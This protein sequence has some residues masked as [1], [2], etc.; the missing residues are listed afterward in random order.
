MSVGALLVQFAFAIP[1]PNSGDG[2]V[3]GRRNK[4]GRE[5]WLWLTTLPFNKLQ[6]DGCVG[7]ARLFDGL[8]EMLN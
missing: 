7:Q 4:W 6:H 1:I 2:A 5:E 8:V 3:L